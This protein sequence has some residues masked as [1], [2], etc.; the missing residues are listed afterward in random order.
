[1]LFAIGFSAF[2]AFTIDLLDKEQCNAVAYE[3]SRGSVHAQQCEICQ[4]HH[5]FHTPFLLTQSIFFVTKLDI[6]EQ[7]V[8][9]FHEYSFS[10][11]NTPLKPPI[12]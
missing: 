11:S 9:V 2:H 3:I 10:Y 1:M 6:D 4:I 5:L 8:K 12:V 7:P